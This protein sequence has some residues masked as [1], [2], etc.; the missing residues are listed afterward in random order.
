MY[1]RYAQAGR[2][3]HKLHLQ[4]LDSLPIGPPRNRRVGPRIREARDRSPRC[5]VAVYFPVQ[6]KIF[7]FSLKK[8]ST[9]WGLIQCL[10]VAGSPQGGALIL[11]G[12][13]GVSVRQQSLPEL[14]LAVGVRVQAAH[15]AGQLH[16]L[17]EGVVLRRRTRQ[18]VSRSAG[19][20]TKTHGREN[21][22]STTSTVA[23]AKTEVPQSRQNRFV[24]VF[25]LLTKYFVETLHFSTLSNS[26]A[27]ANAKVPILNWI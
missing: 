13:E 24:I 15:P 22:T 14:R 16:R 20:E 7:F 18:R 3:P 17:V 11:R 8:K 2:H 25:S 4:T 21:V 10:L 12:S 23:K 9:F 27:S 1:S 19:C 5:E 26:R 6:R